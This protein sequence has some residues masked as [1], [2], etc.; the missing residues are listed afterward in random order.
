MLIHHFWVRRVENLPVSSRQIGGCTI[1]PVP[2]KATGVV[3]KVLRG[4]VV[5]HRRRCGK[6][7]CRCADG[8]ALHEQVILSYSQESRARSVTLPSELIKPV[9]QATQR[10]REARQRLEAEGTASLEAFVQYLKTTR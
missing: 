3:P 7:N 5:T 8:E 6:P 2:E 10:Y 4:T 1:W 9:R